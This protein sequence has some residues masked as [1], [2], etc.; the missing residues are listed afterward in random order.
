VATRREGIDSDGRPDEPGAVLRLSTRGAP[1][2]LLEPP[3]AIRDVH[4]MIEHDGCWFI[5]CSHDEKLVIRRDDEWWEWWPI[6][7][8]TTDE[9]HVNSIVAD[10]ESLHVLAHNWDEPSAIHHFHWPRGGPPVDRSGAVPRVSPELLGS[11]ILGH[12]AHNLWI[13]GDHITVCSSAEGAIVSTDQSR[14]EVGGYPRGLAVTAERIL[15][16]RSLP[17][18]RASRATADAELAVYDRDWRHLRDII[19]PGEG[20]VLDVR[21]PGAVD[22]CDLGRDDEPWRFSERGGW[23]R[24]P[25]RSA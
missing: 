16:G 6:P 19:L 2:E 23:F 12:Q 5:V 4:Q 14:V 13:D 7:D 10:G 9:H 15:V 17:A 8:S 18:P 1:A 11:T 24:L 21:V 25:V 22:E 20:M 3:L